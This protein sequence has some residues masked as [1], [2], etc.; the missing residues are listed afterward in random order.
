MWA[1]APPAS[2]SGFYPA[3]DS[4]A[5]SS[6]Q[7]NRP[8]DQRSW[9]VQGQPHSSPGYFQ[10]GLQRTGTF[11]AS[12]SSTAPEAFATYN[13]WQP[14]HTSFTD[15][16]SSGA[17]V[18]GYHGSFSQT[19]TFQ[20]QVASADAR[21][22]QVAGRWPS[23]Q[24]TPTAS[25]SA[26]SSASWSEAGPGS[27]SA[28]SVR[29]TTFHA[30]RSVYMPRVSHVPETLSV[31][32]GTDTLLH[33]TNRGFVPVSLMCSLVVF[34]T[35]VAG[36][37]EFPVQYWSYYSYVQSVVRFQCTLF[38]C[39]LYIDDPMALTCTWVLRR[40]LSPELCLRERLE[41]SI[42]S[43]G[44]LCSDDSRFSL[45]MGSSCSKESGEEAHVL[46]KVVR[47]SAICL[48]LLGLG[49]VCLLVVTIFVLVENKYFECSRRMEK[50]NARSFH[51]SQARSMHRLENAKKLNIWRRVVKVCCFIAPLCFS[52]IGVV[53]Y[54]Y[55]KD[56]SMQG[57]LLLQTNLKY[58]LQR[59]RGLIMPG[60][61]VFMWLLVGALQGI[62]SIIV[63]RP[64]LDKELST[65]SDL[66]DD[67]R[68]AGLWGGEA[69]LRNFGLQAG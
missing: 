36:A 48:S 12:A 26:S 11:P 20:A 14:H 27:A 29:S 53:N 22:A 17:H 6:F 41:F 46:K 57:G 59:P 24:E 4:F 32:T 23:F 52:V 15:A 39:N 28:R 55:L 25:P 21:A 35:C 67:L 34:A 9:S 18:P 1:A 33:E 43:I 63:T 58:V 62:I 7:S 37:F 56:L 66:V 38:G 60:R 10:A 31:M 8:V 44:E 13:C 65:G 54:M 61:G 5:A 50:V 69:E 64:L 51:S 19:S 30:N 42:F 3:S 49:L 40:H 16:R 2:W 45:I 68:R 47:A